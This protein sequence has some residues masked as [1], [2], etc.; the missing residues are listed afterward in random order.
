MAWIS[1]GALHCRKRNLMTASVSILLKSCASLTCLR[2]CFLP[3]RAKDLSA[4]GIC[5][6]YHHMKL[7]DI[8]YFPSLFSTK[9]LQAK[10]VKWTSQIFTKTAWTLIRYNIIMRKKGGRG[11]VLYKKCL[12]LHMYTNNCTIIKY[13]DIQCVWQTSYMFRPLSATL[14]AVFNKKAFKE[15]LPEDGRKRPQHVWGLPHFFLLLYTIIMQLLKYIEW[16]VFLHWTLIILNFYI[17][18]CV[19]RT[20]DFELLQNK[21]TA[22]YIRSFVLTVLVVLTKLQ[23]FCP[24]SC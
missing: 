9:G 6:F 8:C 15:Y 10:S 14:K 21:V 24:V 17:F 2:A 3:G 5:L 19:G 11:P 1:F 16:I 23:T 20:R 18:P 22:L 7:L 12:C 4:P 13:N